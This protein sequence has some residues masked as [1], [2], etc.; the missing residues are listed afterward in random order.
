MQQR[1]IDLE[2][3]FCEQDALGER[4][5]Y[6]QDQMTEAKK[7]KDKLEKH[8]QRLVSTPLFKSKADDT[9]YQQLETLKEK[10]DKNVTETN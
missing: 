3:Q 9:N 2:K 8:L 6:I 5:E 10:L 4:V 7:E 1:K